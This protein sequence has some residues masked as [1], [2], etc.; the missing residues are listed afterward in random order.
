MTQVVDASEGAERAVELREALVRE[1]R[2]AGMITSDV[3]EAAFR[4]VPRHEFVPPGTPLEQVYAIDHS[5]A[6]KRDEHGAI[7]SSVSAAYIQVRMIEQAQLCPGANVL[8]VGSGG[9][10]A[11]LLAEVVGPEGQVVSVDI[12]PEVIDRAR[13]LLEAAGYGDR[14]TVL[15][16]DAEHGLPGTGQFDA[17]IVTA[18]AWDIPPA[19]RDQLSGNGTLVV[20]LRMNGIT[21]TIAFR[22]EGDHLVSTSAEVAG[23]VPMQGDGQHPEQV[24]ALTDATG[25]QVKLRFDEQAPEEPGLLEGVLTRG[26]AEVW[27]G[28]TIEH[29]VSFADL[30]LW[31][32]SRMAGFCK[33]AAEEGT[34]LAADR[35]GWFPFG[36]VRGD[37][38]ALLA[39]RPALAGT[40]VEFGARGYGPHGEAA[41]SAMVEQVLAWDRSARRGP[42]PTFAFWP[43]SSDP[44]QF[45]AGAAALKKVH[46]VVTIVWPAA[47]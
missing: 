19:W 1:L 32:A 13:A 8:E 47:G 5:V 9:Y 28:V 20:P 23:F 33:L 15:Q 30:H 6:T 11:A 43:A 36:V 21:R 40:G 42:A 34:E 38:F 27:S 16:A 12:D 31:F 44:S 4:T 46:G 39:V 2:S 3:V 14:V 45:P 37:S 29:G 7:V 10:N 25:H 17:I 18:G 24:V 41:A 22:R 26:R 35:K